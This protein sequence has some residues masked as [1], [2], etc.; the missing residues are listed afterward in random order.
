MFLL[1]LLLCYLCGTVALHRQHLLYSTP[2][3]RT[4]SVTLRMGKVSRYF[5]IVKPN[6]LQDSEMIANQE[7]AGVQKDLCIVRDSSTDI[8]ID[9]MH[10]RVAT[11]V[12]SEARVRTIP[13]SAAPP[14]SSITTSNQAAQLTD[15]IELNQTAAIEEEMLRLAV[16]STLEAPD[17]LEPDDYVNTL[18]DTGVVRVNNVIQPESIFQLIGFIQAELADSIHAVTVDGVQPLDRFSNMLSSNNRWDLKLPLDNPIILDAIRKIFNRQTSV[19]KV[20]T[21]LVTERGELFELAAFCTSSG[22]ARQVVH[23]DTLW[24]K[25]PALYTCAIALQDVQE[26]MGPTLFLPG[27]TYF[28]KTVKISAIIAKTEKLNHNCFLTLYTIHDAFHQL[29]FIFQFIYPFVH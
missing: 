16:K 21:S 29:I 1:Q 6:S 12:D 7:E 13:T 20:L 15:Q 3:R 8:S 11:H 2:H 23:A 9:E 28:I 27:Y 10:S 14:I 17:T 5:R 26:D 4:C 19:S 18:R 25:H 24:S 22:A